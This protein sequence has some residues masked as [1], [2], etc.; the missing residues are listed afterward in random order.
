MKKL[1]I[2]FFYL[3]S[4]FIY[5][6]SFRIPFRSKNLWGFA[7]QTGKI[8]A[9]PKYDSV[10]INNENF[11]WF[12]YKN[13]KVGVIDSSGNEKL[14]VEYDSIERKPLH[15]QD[16]DFYLFKNKRKGY[17]DITGK[18]IF[19]CDYKDIVACD[20]I[21]IGKISNFFIKKENENSWELQDYSHTTQINQIQEFKNFYNGNYTIRKGNQW[22]FY[23]VSLKKWIFN[24]EYDE[25]GS[26][27]YKDFY[28]KKKEYSDY[29][30]FAKKGDVFYLCTK[31][32][33]IAEFKNKYEDFFENKRSSAETYEVYTDIGKAEKKSLTQ[34]NSNFSSTYKLSS[35]Y[36]GPGQIKILQ[37]K[38]KFGFQVLGIYEEKKVPPAYDEIQLI[39]EGG[40]YQNDIAFFRKKDKWGI[41]NLKKFV[42]VTE[43]SYNDITLSDI[44]NI[45]LIKN[46]NK[47]GLFEINDGRIDFDTQFIPPVYDKFSTIQYAR[48]LD[49]TYKSFHV[50]FFHKNN[51]IYPVGMNGVQFYQD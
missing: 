19:P 9:S 34:N 42:W 8:K 43:V 16:N 46:K 35:Y 10:S 33:K 38:N 12:V 13:N 47:V 4:I 48:S 28:E 24:A 31:D 25:I 15:S 50:Y 7:D 45:L 21:R 27:S 32:F 29:K 5:S 18:I 44:R 26:L 37:E 30:Y 17:A 49:H 23:N 3:I 2:L 36:G 1:F 51:K 39:F 22:G 11:R 41:F 14:A 6:Q 40:A 20:E